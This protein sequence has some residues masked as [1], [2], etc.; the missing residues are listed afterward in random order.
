MFANARVNAGMIESG[1]L[2]RTQQINM[3]YRVRGVRALPYLQ[4]DQGKRRGEVDVHVLTN[5]EFCYLA[6]TFRW[7]VDES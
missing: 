1:C 2:V 6:L 3:A 5:G 4:G 7:R